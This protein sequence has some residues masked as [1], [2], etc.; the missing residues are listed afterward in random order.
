[1]DH[2][3]FTVESM[4]S[5]PTTDTPIPPLTR[6]RQALEEGIEQ[7]LH[8]GGQ[9]YV[10]RRS[11]VPRDD[12]PFQ[13]LD[14][15]VGER[16]PGQ[17][18][19]AD[20]LMIWLSSSKPVTAVALGQLWERGALA[21]D[22]PIARHIP[23]FAAKGKEK[24]TLRH[25]LTH[26]GGFRLLNVGWPE[27]GWDAII[28][29]ICNSRPEPRWGPGEKAGYHLAASWFIL[30]EVVRRLDGRSYSDYVRQEIF[31]PCGMSDSWIGMPAQRFAAYGDRIGRM[32]GTEASAGTSKT[33]LTRP[34]H[35]AAHV[36]GCSPGGN[37]YGPI[38]QLG[39]FYEM[40]SLGGTWNGQRILSPQAVEALTTPHRV[41][42][43]DHTF[44]HK[45][46]WGLG[47]IVN[48]EHYGAELP[49][50]GY[51]RHASR[52]TFGHSGFQSSTGFCDPCHGLVVALVVNGNPGEPRHTERLRQLTEAIY[53]DLGLGEP[54]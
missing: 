40:L 11:D 18:M 49:P 5:E 4:M 42:L 38:R 36:Q 29:T 23:E 37:G 47:F 35:Q 43:Y 14:L 20:T 32:Y 2:S 24:I 45:L 7:G 17:P 9:V 19:T 50:Y 16:Q 10:A 44:K 51:G 54:L 34:W 6:T 8:F 12:E 13:S 28:A 46:D 31:E 26:T 27:A 52:R 15:V 1:M 33:P 30:G 48:S 25:A 41:G 22:D 21:L 53:E 3:P 39:R